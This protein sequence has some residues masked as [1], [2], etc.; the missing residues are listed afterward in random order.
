MLQ[1]VTNLM[2]CICNYT[3]TLLIHIVCVE[4]DTHCIYK[5]AAMQVTY[6]TFASRPATLICYFHLLRSL[7]DPTWAPPR[8]PAPPTAPRQQ[9]YRDINPVPAEDQAAEEQNQLDKQPPQEHDNHV[10]QG[11][12]ADEH[13]EV[14]TAD[15]QQQQGWQRVQQQDQQQQYQ[16]QQKE[17]QGHQQQL[18]Q[19]EQQQLQQQEQ[20][21]EEPQPEQSVPLADFVALQQLHFQLEARTQESQQQVASLTEQ[22]A[23]RDCKAS[24]GS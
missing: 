12:T 3:T 13:I 1:A 7:Q 8:T 5:G 11:D 21:G 20:Q 4:L 16:Q 19:K 22:H 6:F 17:L 15:Q 23:Q 18:Q 9:R 24:A 2:I 10:D 14:A